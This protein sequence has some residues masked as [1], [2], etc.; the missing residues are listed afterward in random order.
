VIREHSTIGIV[1]TTDG[2]ISDLPRGAY[3]EAEARV[4]AELEEIEKPFIVLLN[5]VAPSAPQAVALAGQLAQQ[6]GH[7]VLPVSCVDMTD[8]DVTE[9]LKSVLFEFPLREIAF[10][11]PKWVMSLKKGHWLQAALYDAAIAFAARTQR[12]KDLVLKGTAVTCE[13]LR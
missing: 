6:Y 11:L 3:E 4:I 7:T 13:Y 1:I 2:S 10:S 5:C 9:I 12:M 8:E